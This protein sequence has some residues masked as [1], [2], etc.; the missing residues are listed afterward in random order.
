MTVA[1]ALVLTLATIAVWAMRLRRR[2]LERVPRPHRPFWSAFSIGL[3]L[4]AIGA[5]Y[6]HMERA[7]GLAIVLPMTEASNIAGVFSWVVAVLLV[8]RHVPLTSRAGLVLGALATITAGVALLERLA[9]VLGWAARGNIGLETKYAGAATTAEG[10]TWNALF[11]AALL[12]LGAAIV[13]LRYL[14]E[15]PL[16]NSHAVALG[17]MLAGIL[18]LGWDW[19]GTGQNEAIVASGQVLAALLAADAVYTSIR[20]G[21]RGEAPTRELSIWRAVS[22]W[23]PFVA[24]LAL[25]LL[26]L[27]PIAPAF[28]SGIFPAGVTYNR[29]VVFAGALLGLALVLG[30][31]TVATVEAERLRHKHSQLVGQNEEYVRLAISDALTHLFNKGYFDYRLKLECERSRRANQPLTLI[32]LD[33]DNFKQVN[34]RYGHAKGDELLVGV[35]NVIRAATRSIDCPCRVGGDEFILILPQTDVDGAATVAERLRQGV[36]DIV[37]K[38]GLATTVSVSCGISAYAPTMR[39][40]SE[41]VEQSDAALYKAKQAGKNQVAIWR[42]ETPLAQPNP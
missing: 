40:A 16:P 25:V 14:A 7:T 28:F 42:E 6:P 20:R 39:D 38:Q 8:C 10:L 15:D 29:E 41:L 2:T 19:I 31:G 9:G 11:L 22:P 4:L 5:V 34:D 37:K 30:R 35:G 18:Y 36:L 3:S 26:A 12:S 21:R 33:L 1:A 32:A 27:E 13:M 24:G 23:L 17:A